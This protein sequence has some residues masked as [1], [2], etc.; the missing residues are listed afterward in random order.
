MLPF[1]MIAILKQAV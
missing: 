1:S